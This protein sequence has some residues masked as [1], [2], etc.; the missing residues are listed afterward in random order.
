M[1]LNYFGTDG[2][3]GLAYES[4]LT[5]DEAAR[6]GA[7]WARVA[8]ERGIEEMV[9][10]W[11]S[12]LSSRPLAEAFVSGMGDAL[13]ACVLG[14]VPTPAVAYAALARDRAW[15]LMI[16]ASHN[17]P[18]DNGIK[19]FD[20]KGEKLSEEDEEAVE[21]AFDA[22]PPMQAAEIPLHLETALPLAY[23]RHLEPLELPEG[24]RVVVDCAHGATAPW[25][26]RV[27]LGGDVRWIGVPEDGARINVGVGSTH[28]DAL[29]AE[30]RAAGAALGIAFDGDGDRCL[31]VDAQGEVVDGDQLLWLLARDLHAQGRP[32]QGVVGTVMTNAGLEAA[33]QGLSIPFVRTPV[34]DK[35]MLRELGRRGWDLAAEASGHLIQK[36]VGPSGD[37]LA[38][39]LAVL[40]A[41]L[42]R[43]AADRWSWRFE[44]WPLR[45][46][47]IVARDRRPVE[48]CP[49]LQEAMAALEAAHGADLRLVVRWSGTEPKLR[50]MVEARTQALMESAIADLEA[51]ARADLAGI[52]DSAR[53]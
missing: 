17:P 2:V 18:E 16:S 51:A 36:H 43:P 49:A 1:P 5:L 26:P 31:M 4:P 38:T 30:V 44:P 39:A 8:Q 29:A 9:L 34:G 42:R 37:G 45:L 24:F 40:R 41:L 35:F 14:L 19:G 53:L 6:W 50:L 32:P 22:L 3:R 48:D 28:L 13:R 33:L 47:N 10:G 25:A 23:I 11:D 15:G 52:A 21:E 7:A 12:R 46:V 20:G 27:I